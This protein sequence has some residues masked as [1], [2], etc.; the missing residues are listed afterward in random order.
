MHI[1]KRIPKGGLYFLEIL[2]LW[3]EN[4]KNVTFY[5]PKIP[6]K[7]HKISMSSLI[8]KAL[9]YGKFRIPEEISNRK[10]ITLSQ[11]LKSS[12]NTADR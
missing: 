3:P 11:C 6:Y 9:T 5:A 4:Y 7:K 1:S 10:A 2:K 8:F 12:E